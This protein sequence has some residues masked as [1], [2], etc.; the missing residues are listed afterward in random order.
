MNS[1]KE[2]NSTNLSLTDDQRMLIQNISENLIVALMSP[3]DRPIPP[4]DLEET[5]NFIQTLAK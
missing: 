5:A 3:S 4:K 2:T 1:L